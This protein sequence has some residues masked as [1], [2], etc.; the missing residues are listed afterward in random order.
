MPRAARGCGWPARPGGGGARRRRRAGTGRAG[1][2]VR[3]V[4]GRTGGSVALEGERRDQPDAVELGAGPERDAGGDRRRRRS[5]SETAS[6]VRAAAARSG[7]GRRGRSA[8]SPP[9]RVVVD[10]HHQDEVLVEQ[11]LRRQVA[12]GHGQRD[13][14]EVEPA[15]GHLGLEARGRPLGDDQADL[16][17]PLGQV[18]RAT[19][20]PATGPS[21]PIIPARTVPPTS[22]RRAPQVAGQGVELARG[23]DRRG[24]PRPRP[25]A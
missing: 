13:E 15:V 19:V 10:G 11:R 16:R 9:Q 3:R 23:R 7:P 24:P 12:P 5:R 21:V 2:A 17:V 4:A 6:P 8:A 1:V 14:G 25:R 18:G 22:S 20:A